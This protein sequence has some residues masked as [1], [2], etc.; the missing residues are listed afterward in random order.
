MAEAASAEQIAEYETQLANVEEL[1]AGSPNDES[2]LTLKKD[3]EELLQLTRNEPAVASV[4]VEPDLPTSPSSPPSLPTSP[5]AVTAEQAVAAGAAAAA[6]ATEDD[7]PT[8]NPPSDGLSEKK[9]TKKLK[10]FV[11]PA[12][13]IVNEQ[14]SEAEKKK[15]RRAL[16]ALKSQHRERRKEVEHEQKQKSW[17]SFQKKKKTT[18]ASAGGSS[19]I[20]ATQDSVNDRVGVISRKTK[21]E[22][23]QRKR[24]KQL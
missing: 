16:K 17:Q 14:D 20:F 7:R 3:L 6:I 19:S 10:D 4:K 5:D 11:V 24:H 21:T 15:K 1:L 2:L 9:K 18:S 13:L 23:G 22:F 12:H 8:I